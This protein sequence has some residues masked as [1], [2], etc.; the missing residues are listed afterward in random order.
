MQLGFQPPVKTKIANGCTIKYSC[1]YISN[2][3]QK[4]KLCAQ[5]PCS[6]AHQTLV[7]ALLVEISASET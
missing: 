2:S 4:K 3:L 1:G 5:T 7:S 6:E